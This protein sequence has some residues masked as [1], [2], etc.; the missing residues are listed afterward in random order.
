MSDNFQKLQALHRAR[1]DKAKSRMA[2]VDKAEADFEERVTQ[3]QVWFGEARDELRAAQGELEESKRE[4]ILKQADIEKAREVAKDQAT[5]VEAARQ[6]Q[7]ALLDSQEEDVVAREQE[8]TAMLHGKDE[9][10]EKIVVQR[11]QELEQK[12]KDALNALALG[13]VKEME[14]ERDGLNKE[15]L[16]LMEGRDTANHALADAR[17]AVSDK[18]KLLSEANDST[19]DLKLKVDGLE[20]TLSEVRAREGTLTKALETEKRLWSDNA[21]A[22]KEYVGSVNLWISRLVDVAGRLTA[23]LAAM[24]LPDVRYSQEPNVSPNARLTLFF[25]GVLEA[26]ERLRSNQAVYLANESRRLCQCAL[27]KVLTKVAFWNPSIDFADA[28]EILPEDADLT[29][30]EEHIEPIISCNRNNY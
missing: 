15:V 2:A 14:L 28:L 18:A 21:T 8:L 3:M 4:L 6:Q 30:L 5:K 13:K 22:H 12:H 1:Q 7:Q 24:G 19:N 25:E 9:E 23:Q 16:E 11:T 29:A 17:A 20:G 26:L 27:T 10:I